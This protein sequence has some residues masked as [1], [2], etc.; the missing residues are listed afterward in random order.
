VDSPEALADYQA[1]KKVH[2]AEWERAAPAPQAR[3]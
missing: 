2:K 3:T 1:E